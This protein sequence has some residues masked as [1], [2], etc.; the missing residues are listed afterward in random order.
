MKQ[1]SSSSFLLFV[2]M[3]LTAFCVLGVAR[4]GEAQ[5]EPF[6]GVEFVCGPVSPED[7]VAVPDEPWVVS[8]GMEDDGYLYATHA[9]EHRTTVPL[10]HRRASIAAK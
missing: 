7:L 8:A 10:S 9:R 6:E 1:Q 4:P 5:C 2:L 3:S